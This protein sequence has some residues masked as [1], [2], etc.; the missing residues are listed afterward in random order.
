[1]NGIYGKGRSL[2]AV[3]YAEKPVYSVCAAYGLEGIQSTDVEELQSLDKGPLLFRKSFIFVSYGSLCRCEF[4]YIEAMMV[5][6]QFF[7][8][9]L[10]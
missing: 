5:F 7:F 6:S 9:A 1:M 3:E 10:P 2:Q 4:E 8:A